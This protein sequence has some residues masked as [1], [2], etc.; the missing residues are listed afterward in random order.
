MRE[1]AGVIIVITGIILFMKPNIDST[2][3]VLYF[4]YIATNYWPVG[5]ILLGIF[6]MNPKKKKIR[7]KTR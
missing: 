7:N 6:L 4:N 5:L 1:R 2:Q 3:W